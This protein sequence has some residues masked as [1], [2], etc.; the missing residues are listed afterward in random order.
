MRAGQFHSCQQ[1]S[2]QGHADC[3]ALLAAVGLHS[4]QPEQ[5]KQDALLQSFSYT[6]CNL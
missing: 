1:G 5:E 6:K 2:A 4:R 3:S